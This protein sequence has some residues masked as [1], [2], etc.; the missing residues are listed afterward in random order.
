MPAVEIAEQTTSYV[1]E[2]TPL[3]GDGVSQSIARIVASTPP[4]PD[5]LSRNQRR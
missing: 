3:A 5:Y 1:L 2:A 4:A